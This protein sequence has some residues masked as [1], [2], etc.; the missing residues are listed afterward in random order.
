MA[1]AL[2]LSI[3]TG[4]REPELVLSR[5]ELGLADWAVFEP[6]DRLLLMEQVRLAWSDYPRGLALVGRRLDVADLVRAALGEVPG[7]AEDFSKLLAEI[8]PNA[9]RS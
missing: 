8:D 4:P 5:L 9:I 2:R 1:R 3:M 6:D 7:A